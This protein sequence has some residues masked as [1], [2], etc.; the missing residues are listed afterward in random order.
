MNL[1]LQVALPRRELRGYVRS[2][3]QR[4]VRL[5]GT[6]IREAVPPRL[7]QTLEFQ[8]RDPF[9]VDFGG[10]RRTV[11]PAAVIVGLYTNRADILL[12]REV[13]S[14][15]IFF[16]PAGLSRLFRVPVKE[17]LGLHFE[18]AS[19]IG[20]PV[21]LLGQ[22]LAGRQFE[23]RVRISEEFLLARAREIP[24]ADPIVEAAEHL[25]AQRGCTRISELAGHCGLGIRQF[26]RKFQQRLG[27]APK[28]YARVARFQ[29][30]L[31]AKMAQPGRNW[32][33]IAHE[34]E[35]HDQMHMIREFKKLGGGVPS[36]LVQQVGDCRPPAFAQDG[37]VSLAL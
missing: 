14:F 24:F 22:R 9:I 34:L 1:T 5:A 35:Y 17:L 2:Y 16:Q 13:E 26:E 7:E 21:D 19:V 25:F 36:L 6:Q 12:D 8:F 15:G 3:A 11:T 30:A 32:L 29:T 37:I 10:G 23:D 18:A 4:Y 20:K 33:D 28:I 31:D 27:I